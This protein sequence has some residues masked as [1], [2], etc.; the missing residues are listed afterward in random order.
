MTRELT[1]DAEEEGRGRATRAVT[2]LV[3]LACLWA[4]LPALAE[5]VKARVLSVNERKSEVRADVAG[6]GA[7]T[8]STTA[9]RTASCA[10]GGW[11]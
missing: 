6:R 3:A 9:R 7:T 5:T 2:T 4:P 11:W 8:A 10:R 1:A